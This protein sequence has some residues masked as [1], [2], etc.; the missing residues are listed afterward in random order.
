M[1][2]V[3]SSLAQGQTATPFETV[4]WRVGRWLIAF[5][6]VLGFTWQDGALTGPPYTWTAVWIALLIALVAPELA[7]IWLPT[8]FHATLGF[9]V[10]DSALVLLLS[11]TFDYQLL[12]LFVPLIVSTSEFASAHLPRALCTIAVAALL[13]LSWRLGFSA[14]SLNQLVLYCLLFIGTA[15]IATFLG[16]NRAKESEARLELEKGLEARSD[17]FLMRAHEIRTPLTLIRASV[18]LL[19][20]GA[21]GPLTDQ[22]RI[23]LE[24]VDENSQHMGLLA[25]NM[26]TRSKLE[27][28]VFQPTFQAID[29]RDPIRTVVGDMRTFADRRSQEIRVHYPQILSMIN[30]D[31]VLLRQALTNLIRN[32]IQHTSPG[33]EIMVSI[34]QNDLNLLISV[35]DDGAGMTAEQRKQVF[36]RFA[37]GRGGTGLGL[38]IVKQIVELHDGQIFIDTNLG[39]GTTFMLTFPYLAQ[40]SEI[41]GQK[42]V[43]RSS[44]NFPE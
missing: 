28:A 9:I 14:T 3:D 30:A 38:M 22:Q 31:S 36:Q 6:L 44:P 41:D 27:S 33:G 34:V 15:W 39:Q 10:G 24:N 20:D 16:R 23:F 17:Y 26:L 25:E 32:A 11:T 43:V 2:L 29:V 7:S 21:P 19:L 37:T 1:I 35:T 12:L 5:G 40:L 13:L 42:S 8:R 4:H 18:E